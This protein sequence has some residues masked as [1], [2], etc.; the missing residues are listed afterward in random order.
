MPS[1]PRKVLIEARELLAASMPIV[2]VDAPRNSLDHLGTRRD[3]VVAA[4]DRAISQRL[5]R[6]TTPIAKQSRSGRKQAYAFRDIRV[7]IKKR[8]GDRCEC[9]G[10][11]GLLQADH[12]YGG[13]GRRGEMQSVETVWALCFRCH[14]RKTMNDPSAVYWLEQFIEHCNRLGFKDGAGPARL[15]LSSLLAQSKFPYPK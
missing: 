1:V 2:P 14:R 15:R 5:P 13:S 4:L 11:R 9:C 3:R 10:E 12:F 8:A 7:Q 6:R